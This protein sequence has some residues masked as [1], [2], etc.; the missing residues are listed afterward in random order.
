M[1]EDN[2][3]ADTILGMLYFFGREVKERELENNITDLKKFTKIDFNRVRQHLVNEGYINCDFYD[4]DDENYCSLTFKGKHFYSTG[5]FLPNRKEKLNRWF[6]S[7]VTYGNAKWV[8]TIILT[9][10]SI[11]LSLIAILKK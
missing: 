4:L 6:K 3:I 10:T 1:E 2:H 8:V 9:V 11:T 5:G 7:D